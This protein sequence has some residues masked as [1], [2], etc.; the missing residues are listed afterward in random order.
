MVAGKTHGRHDVV[1]AG[2]SSDEPRSAVDGT[3]PH[4]A[5]FVV[6]LF[7]RLQ[8]SAAEPGPQVGHR[9][10]VDG[11]HHASTGCSTRARCSGSKN[12]G[13]DIVPAATLTNASMAA[14]LPAMDAFVSVA[15]GT[16]SPPEYFD[17]EHLARVLQPV[18]A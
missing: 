12:S 4:P 10:R 8:Q 3:V 2:T 13:G 11:G 14:W 9:G 18:E 1:G 5:G 7:A 17:P 15:A 16:M 6:A